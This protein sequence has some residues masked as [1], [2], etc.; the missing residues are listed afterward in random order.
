MDITR[1]IDD[2]ADDIFSFALITTKDFNSAKEIFVKISTASSESTDEPDLKSLIQNA[3]NMAKVADANEEAMTLT[4][5]ELDSRQQQLLEI[6]LQKP[7]IVRSII[8]MTWEN[9]FEPAEISKITGESI[10]YITSVISGFSNEITHALDKH[11]KDICIN[12]F[13]EDVLKAYVIRSITSGKTRRFE[14]KG[15]AVPQHKWSKKQKISVVIIAVVLTLA[16]FVVM[17]ILESYYQMRRE[18]NF[19][20]FENLSTDEIFR[21]T[22]EADI[23]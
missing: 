16:V 19:E 21:Y 6:I 4:G 13:A 5:I 23:E 10:K 3:Y 2:F 9:D 15:D 14:V 18:E 12:I 17:P 7:F 22:Y 1:F 8:H 11:Y 20:S